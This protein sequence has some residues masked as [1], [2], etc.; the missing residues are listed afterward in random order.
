MADRVIDKVANM[1]ARKT[2]VDD[3]W[4]S[5]AFWAGPSISWWPSWWLTR[6]PVK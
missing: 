3:D 1:V 6:W 2:L 5:W 4:A